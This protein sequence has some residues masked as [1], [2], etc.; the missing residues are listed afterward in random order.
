MYVRSACAA[1]GAAPTGATRFGEVLKPLL[2]GNTT[3]GN[4]GQKS[5]L[6]KYCDAWN[7]GDLDA[8]F[9]LFAENARYEGVSTTL[10]GRDAI[11]TMYER[12]FASGEAKE[13]TARPVETD[14]SACSVEIHKSGECVAVKQFEICEG[15]IIRQSMLS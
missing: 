1:G 11:R 15:F 10:I 2:G 8:M 7:R 6:E 14:A 3:H 12:T 9:A 4:T 13:L 5:L